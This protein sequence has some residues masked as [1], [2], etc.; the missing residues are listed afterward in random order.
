MNKKQKNKN[1]KA[2]NAFAKG[3]QRK[4]ALE[5]GF[6]DGRFKT[7]K[8]KDKK[9]EADKYASRKKNSNEE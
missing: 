6:Y 4:L 1:R 7:K 3:I 5:Q 2:T 8:V 9:K